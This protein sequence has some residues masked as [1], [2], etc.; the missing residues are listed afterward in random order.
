MQDQVRRLGVDHFFA[1]PKGHLKV[2]AKR[3]AAVKKR[4]AIVANLRKLGSMPKI[5]VAGIQPAA[6]FGYEVVQADPRTIS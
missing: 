2:M 4:S 5:D 1:K 3:T 6:L